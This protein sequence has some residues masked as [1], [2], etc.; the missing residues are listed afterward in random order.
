MIA[1]G[2]ARPSAHGHA[3]IST[4]TALTSANASRGGGPQML[5]ADERQRTAIS[6]DGRHEERGDAIRQPLDRRAAAL[7]LADH[8]HDLREQRVAA[9]A[10]GAEQQRAG[11][12]DRAAGHAI[13]RRLLGRASARR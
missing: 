7:R 1:I 6:D 3:M 10:L 13:A 9:D 8:P 4:A 11:G 5:H 2:V 12:V